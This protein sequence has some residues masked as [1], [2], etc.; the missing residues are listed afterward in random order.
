MRTN[1]ALCELGHTV[2]EIWKEDLGPR[3]IAHG[4]LHSLLEQPRACKATIEKAAAKESYDLII[5]QQ[6]QSY[7]AALDHRRKNRRG[8]FFTFSQG[9]ENRIS[10][11]LKRWQEQLGT[12]ARGHPRR[13]ASDMLAV[14]L[15]RQ[16]HRAV[17]Y[18]DGIVVQHTEDAMYIESMGA[19]AKTPVLVCASGLD[20]A[21]LEKPTKIMSPARLSKL[22]FVGQCA[23]YKGIHFLSAIVNR[24]LLENDQ[25]SFT[26]VCEEESHGRAGLLFDPAIRQRVQ[27]RD[28]MS[29]QELLDLYDAHGILI[30][31]TI[32]EGFAKVP[33]EAMSRGM[34][35]VAS[36]CCGMA[37]YVRSGQD[38]ILCEVGDTADFVGR[39]RA[40]NGSV[41]YSVWL[42]TNAR[43]TALRYTWRN[44]AESIVQ[45][46]EEVNS[47]TRA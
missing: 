18:S 43:T 14:P 31:P 22:L 42:S 24:L 44:S 2:Q 45:F 27:F 40:L 19:A 37:D 23:F 16:W 13:L 4:N 39:V 12:D 32:A 3:R 47:A 17:A 29:Q 41:E 28:W 6:P 46:Y 34:C 26:W 20:K 1:A 33:L 35:V 7:L 9:V 36:N 5:S 21:Y 11:L 15:S 38:G 25:L 10:P 30:F 8:L